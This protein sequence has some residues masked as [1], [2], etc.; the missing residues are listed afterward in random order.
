MG[1]AVYDA[2]EYD[3]GGFGFVTLRL[4][5]AA[6]FIFLK[7]WVERRYP[8]LENQNERARRENQA[9]LNEMR[10]SPEHREAMKRLR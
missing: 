9:A 4:P 5:F 2:M 8:E 7:V 10:E 6:P 3:L 1:A